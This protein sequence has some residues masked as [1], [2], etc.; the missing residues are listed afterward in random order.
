MLKFH[1]LEVTDVSPEGEAATCLTFAV[2]PDLRDAYRFAAGQHLGIRTQLGGEEVR[3][4]YSIVSAPG[5][6]EL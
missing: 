4:T 1:A 5:D 3:R 6:P 2:P